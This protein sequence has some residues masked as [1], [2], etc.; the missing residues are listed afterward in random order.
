MRSRRRSLH[1]LHIWRRMTRR[2]QRGMCSRWTEERR[3]EG[4]RAGDGV[5]GIVLQIRFG[6]RRCGE[7]QVWEG[8]DFKSCRKCPPKMS[9]LQ[10]AAVQVPLG[11]KALTE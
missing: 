8:H 7:E 1:C 10:F 11:L 2:M 9:A 5:F 4:W 6:K 3:R